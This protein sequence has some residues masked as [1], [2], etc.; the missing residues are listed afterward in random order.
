MPPF[1]GAEARAIIEGAYGKPVGEVF[2]EFDETPLAA[3]SI[4][5][6][7]TARLRSGED[8]VVKVVRPGI[9]QKIERDL[10]VMY[11]L[12]RLARDYSKEGHRL[13]PVRGRAGVREDHPRRARPDARSGQRGAAAA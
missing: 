4:A 5:Q 13:R 8:V 2:A 12:A 6:V 9:R 3:A 7:H 10:E 11:V 1:P